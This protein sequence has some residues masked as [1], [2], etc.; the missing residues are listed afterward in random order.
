MKKI[1][2]V[3]FGGGDWWYHNRGH[4]DMQLMRRFAQKGTAVYVNSIVMQKPKIGRSH[5]FPEKLIRKVKSISRGLRPSGEGF[6]VYSPFALPVQHIR[7]ARP[8]NEAFL[9]LQ[10]RKVIRKLHINNP[11]IWVTC[12]AAC[13]V[14]LKLRQ[15]K[16]I[17]QRTDR[18]E[19]FPNVDARLIRQFD[20]KLKSEAD[21]T[22]FV[23]R[24]LYEQEGEQ[25]RSAFYLDH[26]V[27]YE[28]FASA[29][30]DEYIPRDIADIRKPIVGFFGGIDNHTSDIALLEAVIDRL[31][32]VDFVFV[33][34]ASV[35]CNGLL[36][37]SNVRMLGQKPYEEVPHYGKCFDVAMMPWRQNRWI[38]ACNPIKLK[39]Y[40]ALGKPVVSTPFSELEKYRDVVYE[41]R[42]PEDFAKCIWR[43][44]QE[45]SPERIQARKEKVKAATWDSKAELVLQRLFDNELS[46]HESGQETKAPIRLAPSR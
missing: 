15:N 19:E 31:P 34:K 39:E 28:L 32:Q 43:A 21:L 14:A 24:L 7:W 6:W 16:L 40:L 10:L 22:V 8:L 18:W 36:A 13:N 26:G 42:T 25:C 27:D 5:N 1:D 35:D 30:N 20:Q 37:H 23:S 9:M 46:P 41:A 17:W 45:D 33:G 12:P 2:V 44:L 3:C 38:E 4:I 29:V 11:L